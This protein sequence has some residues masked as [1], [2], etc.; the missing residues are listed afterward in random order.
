MLT[1][2]FLTFSR[3]HC[4]RP[5]TPVC[6]SLYT[7]PNVLVHTLFSTSVPILPCV[8]VCIPFPMS[9]FIPFSALQSL[10]FPVSVL[11]LPRLSPYSSLSHSL[12]F[13]VSVP[14]LP[15]LSPYPSHWFSRYPLLSPS[16][17]LCLSLPFP[18]SQSLPGVRQTDRQTDRQTKTHRHTDRD[19]ER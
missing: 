16:H 2:F 11:T 13:P 4:L 12:P 15:I 19:R 5:Y 8:S 18:V 14:T 17:P 1:V 9:W 7:L 3:A 10:T 6:P